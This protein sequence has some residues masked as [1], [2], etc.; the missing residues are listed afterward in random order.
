MYI[1]VHSWLTKATIAAN[2]TM[3]GKLS[4]PQ[5]YRPDSFLQKATKKTKEAESDRDSLFPLLTSERTK[6]WSIFLTIPYINCVTPA[7]L[8]LDP[9]WDFL[10]GDPLSR[11]L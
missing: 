7:L 8:T 5:F 4:P 11:I 3:P 2:T 6:R 10:R 1:S 9:K